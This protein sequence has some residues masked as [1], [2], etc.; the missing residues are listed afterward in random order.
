MISSRTCVCVVF[1]VHTITYIHIYIYIGVCVC[2]FFK[3]VLLCPKAPAFTRS[4]LAHSPFHD[5][6]Q[7]TRLADI[8]MLL[9]ADPCSAMPRVRSS[10]CEFYWPRR[11]KRSSLRSRWAFKVT[12]P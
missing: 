4:I 2:V 1:T 11:A 6:T 7:V 8:S 3:C 12:T 5:H 10:G 9:M